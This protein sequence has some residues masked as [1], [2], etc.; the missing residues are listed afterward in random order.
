MRCAMFFFSKSVQARV[1]GDIV[2]RTED[3]SLDYAGRRSFFFKVFPAK[4]DI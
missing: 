4:M 1:R 2:H 3:A